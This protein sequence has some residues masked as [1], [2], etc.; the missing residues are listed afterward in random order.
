M[1]RENA[2]LLCCQQRIEATHPGWL[3]NQ[4][5]TVFPD[6]SRPVQSD[7]HEVL[8]VECCL[9]VLYVVGVILK[10]SR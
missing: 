6:G 9:G 4:A 5:L 8:A 1:C 7:L 2:E 3:L 10:T